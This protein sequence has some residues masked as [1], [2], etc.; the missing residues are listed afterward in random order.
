VQRARHGKGK[1]EMTDAFDFDA[2][3]DIRE[4]VADLIDR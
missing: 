3:D 2:Y 4:A 1:E